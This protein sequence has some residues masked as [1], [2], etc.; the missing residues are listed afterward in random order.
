MEVLEAK[1]HDSPDQEL[2]IVSFGSHMLLLASLNGGML[3]VSRWNTTQKY[4]TELNS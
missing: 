2:G 3:M 4:K 1:L